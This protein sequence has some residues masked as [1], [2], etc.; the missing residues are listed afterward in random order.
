MRFSAFVRGEKGIFANTL[1][2]GIFPSW[3]EE[4]GKYRNI[5]PG[6]VAFTK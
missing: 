6:V 3:E 2:R 4:G 1:I 5:V